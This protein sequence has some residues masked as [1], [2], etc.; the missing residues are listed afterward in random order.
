MSTYCPYLT[1]TQAA[2][3]SL[4]SILMQAEAERCGE[5]PHLLHF[6]TDSYRTMEQTVYAAEAYLFRYMRGL[7][8]EDR[9]IS[10]TAWK[11]YLKKFEE[12]ETKTSSKH[13]P[14]NE[15]NQQVLREAVEGCMQSSLYLIIDMTGSQE[16]IKRS[17]IPKLREFYRC[18]EESDNGDDPIHRVLFCFY[19]DSWE[20]IDPNTRSFSPWGLPRDLENKVTEVNYPPI[21]KEDIES[22][23][24]EYHERYIR[25]KGLSEGDGE[26]SFDDKTCNWYLDNLKGVS[27]SGIRK[28]FLSFLKE[29]NEENTSV[30]DLSNE[31]KKIAEQRIREYKNEILKKHALLEVIKVKPQKVAGMS[32]ITEDWLEKNVREK[33]HSQHPPKGMALAGLPGTGKTAAAKY[34]ST[35]LKLPLIRLDISM[36]LGRYVGESE[37]NMRTA[38]ADLRFAAPCVLWI[39]E[40]EKALSGSDGGDKNGIMDRIFGQLLT[41]MQENNDQRV[42]YVV[43]ANDVSKIRPEFFRNGRFD[44]TY[45]LLFP[46]YAE[47]LE[48]MAVQLNAFFIEEDRVENDGFTSKDDFV[49]ELVDICIGNREEPHFL[50]GANIEQYVKELYWKLTQ[51]EMD[52]ISD[53]E[54]EKDYKR[55]KAKMDEISGCEHESLFINARAAVL[56]VRPE[57]FPRATETME[58]A[59]ETYKSLLERGFVNGGDDLTYTAENLDIE[60]VRAY[61]VR[62]EE[63]DKTDPPKALIEFKGRSDAWYDLR[64]YEELNKALTRVILFKKDQDHEYGLATGQ[65]NY[66]N[67]G[68]DGTKKS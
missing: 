62:A 44:R 15:V 32:K 34:A 53:R 37:T 20:N 3:E 33:I 17:Y 26:I 16:E 57:A 4:V 31:K 68:G 28:V 47:L 25:Q 58:R 61:W 7:Q 52:A 6:G 63:N 10:L 56:K 51:K 8:E 24:R 12:C 41:F 50:T 21:R 11:D 39:D 65:L 64:L 9:L 35:I 67:R 43:T 27:E 46:S 18:V 60:R 54:D 29:E 23:L 55:F 59:A 40:I 42:F 1:P 5:G 22:L 13:Q 30:F 48:I 49:R 19:G 38:L 66:W 36:I 45:C 14:S 2:G